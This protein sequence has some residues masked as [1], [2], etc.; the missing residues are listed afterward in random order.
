MLVGEDSTISNFLLVAVMAGTLLDFRSGYDKT[1]LNI[2]NVP[3][4][5]EH[6]CSGGVA[7][8]MGEAMDKDGQQWNMS[9]TDVAQ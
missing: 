3:A 9:K 2:V 8:V 7:G 4:Q 5:R 1:F 6:V